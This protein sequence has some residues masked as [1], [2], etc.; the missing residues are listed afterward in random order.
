MMRGLAVLWPGGLALVAREL[1]VTGL[2]GPVLGSMAVGRPEF[3]GTGLKWRN[4][5]LSRGPHGWPRVAQVLVVLGPRVLALVDVESGRPWSVQ[6]PV[7]RSHGGPASGIVGAGCPMAWVAQH[8][9]ARGPA[10]LGPGGP[11]LGGMGAS[12]PEPRGTGL[13]KGGG[14]LSRGPGGWPHAAQGT[15]NPGSGVSSSSGI[16]TGQPELQDVGI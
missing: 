1:A 8:Q 12:R 5:Q 9:V 16:G 7:F 3:Q 2:M 15:A 4:G 6:G 14:R 10:I 13:G 11:A